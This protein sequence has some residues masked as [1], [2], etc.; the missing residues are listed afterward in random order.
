MG[1]S[2]PTCA[3]G[4]L[5]VQNC[6]RLCACWCSLVVVEGQAMDR[7]HRLGQTRDVYVYRLVLRGTV[8]ERILERASQ[9][10]TVQHLV[11]ASDKRGRNGS[12]QGGDG[13]PVD[14][15]REDLLAILGDDLI[16]R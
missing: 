4:R 5:R 2:L 10:S 15:R 12:S 16:K 1:R 11:M 14:L 6:V 9:K 7:A 8:E 13:D 3:D